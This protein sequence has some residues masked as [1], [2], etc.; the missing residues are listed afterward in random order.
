MNILLLN[1]VLALAW[2]A[3]T[4]RYTAANFGVGFFLA[5]I[6]IWLSHRTRTTAVYVGKIRNIL[7]FLLFFLKELTLSNLRVAYE[8]LTPRH[9]MRPGIIAIPL[10]LKTDLEITVLTSLITLTPGTL[11]L[12]V[13][14]DRKTLYIHAMFIENR[15]QMRRLIKDGFERRVMEVFR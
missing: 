8:V 7:S 9:H 5:L 4:G 6:V 13:S 10:D 12:D 1:I 2:V 3:L 14:E 15:E 11:S